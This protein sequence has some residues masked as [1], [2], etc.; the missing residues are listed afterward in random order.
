[1][2][3]VC[4]V[5]VLMKTLCDAGKTVLVETSGACDISACDGRVI[6]IMDLKTPGSGEADRNL[7]T[8]IDHLTGR[9]EVKF[10]ICDREDYLWSRDIIQRYRLH[11]RVVRPTQVIVSSGPPQ[12][13][14]DD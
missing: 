7:W 14:D 4:A 1:M 3:L 12:T 11:D 13:E 5:H 8:N 6:R 2:M 10:V 9:D